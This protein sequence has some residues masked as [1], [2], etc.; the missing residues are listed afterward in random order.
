METLA[1][2]VSQ[3]GLVNQTDQAPRGPREESGKAKKQS[4]RR[5]ARETTIKDANYRSF[6]EVFLDTHSKNLGK[7]RAKRPS[8]RKLRGGENPAGKEGEDS[9]AALPGEGGRQPPKRSQPAQRGTPKDETS[10]KV[11]WGAQ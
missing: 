11:K 10:I 6:R 4:K 5:P 1:S 9:S 2:I 7:K 8:Q 3:A